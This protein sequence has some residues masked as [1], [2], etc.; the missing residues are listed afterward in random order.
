MSRL[1]IIKLVYNT[2][3]HRRLLD[4]SSA[5]EKKRAFA[6]D[7]TSARKSAPRCHTFLKT[8]QPGSTD[9]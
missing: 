4:A 9:R 8:E 5:H 7:K 1:S 3:R 2:G 6:S